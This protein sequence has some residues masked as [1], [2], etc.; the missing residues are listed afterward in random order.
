MADI[1][2]HV[3]ESIEKGP[4]S[5]LNG[6][7]AV[8][9]AVCATMMALCNVKDGNVGQAMQQ[10]QTQAVDQWSF[11]QSKSTKAHIAENTAELLRIQLDMAVAL[12]PETKAML[13]TKIAEYQASAKRYDKEKSEIQATA[14]ALEKTYQELNSF[15]DQ[16]DMADA[17]LSVAIAMFG[18]SALTQKKKLF[19]FA[20]LFAGFGIAF[21]ASGF[22]H[23]NLHPD[24]LANFLG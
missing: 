18:I 6:W 16:F 13:E 23:G 17:C 3:Q 10:A 15:D 19:W 12:K 24:W 11:Y 21:G 22:M 1:A 9:V 8:L 14:K 20:V 7:V 2:D 5:K 4:E